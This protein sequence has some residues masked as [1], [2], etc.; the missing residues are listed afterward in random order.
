MR[1]SI[2][3]DN[4]SEFAQFALLG[5]LFSATTYLCAADAS[6][7]KG[8]IESAN[9][10]IRRWP[11][12]KAEL[13]AMTNTDIQDITV[14]LNLTARKCLGSVIPLDAFL[15]ETRSNIQSRFST[16][17]GRRAWPCPP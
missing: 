7:Q 17:L 5:G 2:T 16:R 11:P 1:G 15:A 10:H 14:T 6:W 8:G 4:G 3:F 13:Y 12:R 9:G